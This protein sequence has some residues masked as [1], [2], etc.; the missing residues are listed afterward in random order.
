MRA[1]I[2]IDP[3]TKCGWAVRS[4]NGIDNAGTWDLTP[5]RFEGAGMRYLRL[6]TWFREALELVKPELV[7]FEEV[8]RHMGVDAAHVYGAIV[9]VIQAECELRKIPYYGLPVATV[10]RTATGKGNADKTAMILAAALRW[11]GEWDAKRENEADA[12]WIA[13]TAWA[14]FGGTAAKRSA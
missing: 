5:K 2:A 14:E 6:R 9:G 10:K 3:G 12:R 11:G 1:L 8:R 7:A 13:E 4:P